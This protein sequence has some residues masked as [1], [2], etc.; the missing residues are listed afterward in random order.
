MS[1]NDS[2]KEDPPTHDHVW[3]DGKWVKMTFILEECADIVVLNEW[4]PL[5]PLK[6]FLEAPPLDRHID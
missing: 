6:T 3:V 4:G 5:L 2:F 1:E